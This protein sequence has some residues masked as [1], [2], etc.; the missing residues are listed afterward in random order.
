VEA[1]RAHGALAGSTVN[2]V[3]IPPA[4]CPFMRRWKIHTPGLSGT[5][6]AIA[7]IGVSMILSVRMWCARTALR[8]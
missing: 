4:K 6:S 7:V 8:P 5:M 3:Y 1:G 2:R